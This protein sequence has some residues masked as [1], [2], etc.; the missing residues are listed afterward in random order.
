MSCVIQNSGVAD[1]SG[2]P[3]STTMNAISRKRFMA[4]IPLRPHDGC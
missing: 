2:R 3:A 4:L 1:S